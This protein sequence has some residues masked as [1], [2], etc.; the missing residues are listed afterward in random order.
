MDPKTLSVIL[1]HYSVAFTLDTYSYVLTD[2]K[3]KEM[4]LMEELFQAPVDDTP[5]TYTIIITPQNDGM[6]YFTAPDFPAVSFLSVD[7]QGGGQHMKE[8]IQEEVLTGY[9]VP[10]G[11]GEGIVLEGNQML[12]QVM[13]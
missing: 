13:M 10:C 3:V 8:R 12:V 5:R 6:L 9:A 1:G 4:G 2:H 11:A 7:L